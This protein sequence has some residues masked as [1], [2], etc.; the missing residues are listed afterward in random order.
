MLKSEIKNK[1][2]ATSLTIIIVMWI[3]QAGS[4]ES[5]HRCSQQAAA[6]CLQTLQ[7][8]S[9]GTYSIPT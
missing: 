4:A 3:F 2:L 8:Q 1:L 5:L 9:T 6:F 7:L